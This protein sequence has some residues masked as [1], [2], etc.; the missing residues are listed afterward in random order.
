MKIFWPWVT[1]SSA[2]TVITSGVICTQLWELTVWGSSSVP[3]RSTRHRED[4]TRTWLSPLILKVRIYQPWFLFLGSQPPPHT[5]TLSVHCLLWYQGQGQWSSR[6]IVSPEKHNRWLS[7]VQVRQ[8]WHSCA[9]STFL[10]T[11]AAIQVSSCWYPCFILLPRLT[12]SEAYLKDIFSR[13]K[14]LK[15][16]YTPWIDSEHIQHSAQ[17]LFQGSGS[18]ALP[19]VIP[20][21]PTW[22]FCFSPARWHG[23]LS[24]P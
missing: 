2:V 12:P 21:L 24:V 13:F 23:R 15:W 9:S 6:S 7:W 14:P 22:Y 10:A 20:N 17:S 3:G 16:C 8:N 1:E 19:R 4:K 11:S 5:H 18:S